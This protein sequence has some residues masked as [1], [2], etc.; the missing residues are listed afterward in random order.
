ML[1]NRKVIFENKV[2]PVKKCSIHGLFFFIL[3][4]CKVNCTNKCPW[5]N[6]NPSPLVWDATNHLTEPQPQP[7][8]FA[9]T[10]PSWVDQARQFCQEEIINRRPSLFNDESLS[11]PL[12]YNS[13]NRLYVCTATT[14]YCQLWN[15]HPVLNL[16]FRV[17]ALFTICFFCLYLP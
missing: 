10:K 2:A 13:P 5:L 8:I 4:S 11:C 9:N 6:S 7:N 16:V 3:S 12:P 1:L 14:F 17:K 15:D